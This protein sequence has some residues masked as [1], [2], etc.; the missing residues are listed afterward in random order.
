MCALIPQHT[1]SLES[2]GLQ[3][4]IIVHMGKLIY[5]KCFLFQHCSISLFWSP[6]SHAKLWHSRKW[7]CSF[8]A[9]MRVE[10][11]LKSRGVN[12][13]MYGHTCWSNSLEKQAAVDLRRPALSVCVCVCV[14]VLGWWCRALQ[15]QPIPLSCS[16]HASES[17]SLRSLSV[18]GKASKTLKVVANVSRPRSKYNRWQAR[19]DFSFFSI[20]KQHCQRFLEWTETVLCMTDT[21]S[22]SKISSPTWLWC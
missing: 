7:N 13:W 9:G 16:F 2:W 21:L 10:G 6:R 11:L 5:Q 15:T 3:Y 19:T 1:Q 4:P 12:L 20:W 22:F 14:C 17:R 8:W 18:V